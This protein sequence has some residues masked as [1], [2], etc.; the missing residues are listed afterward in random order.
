MHF[1]NPLVWNRKFGH[2][3]SGLQPNITAAT[4][5][6][7]MKPT[8]TSGGYDSD[9]D[10]IAL[11][12]NQ[13]STFAWSR[14]IGTGVDAGTSA[15]GLLLN[16]W[17]TAYET[18]GHTFVLDLAALPLVDGGTT[19]IIDVV[20]QESPNM[21]W[22]SIS[23]IYD[24]NTPEHPWGWKTRPR[25]FNDDA[26]R[27]MSVAGSPWPP[28]IGSVWENGEPIEY[29]A[30]TSWDMS[31]ALTTNREYPE[32]DSKSADINNDGIVDFKDLA[33]LTAQW[34]DP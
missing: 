13:G 20:N 24:G 12:L 9:N 11:Q 15:P 21:Y 31:F 2:T 25:F 4:L 23:A 18:N 14:R 7:R 19:S 27:I 33:I 6:I 34:L 26:V 3:I 30:G 8:D 5:E 22:L 29:P 10:T 32:G 28:V 16:K 17:D 1:D